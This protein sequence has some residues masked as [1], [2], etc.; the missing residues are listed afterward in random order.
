MVAETCGL[1]Y[2]QLVEE[3]PR[4]GKEWL[5]ADVTDATRGAAKIRLRFRVVGK[6]RVSNYRLIA[7]LDPV[8]LRAK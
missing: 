2:Q 1:D 5:T 4:A 8:R 6:R 7:L 3:G